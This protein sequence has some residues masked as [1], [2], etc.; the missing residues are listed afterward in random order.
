MPEWYVHIDPAPPVSQQFAVASRDLANLREACRRI[1]ETYGLTTHELVIL[2]NFTVYVWLNNPC[3]HIVIYPMLGLE[4][5]MLMLFI[6]SPVTVDE[7]Q[8]DT[9]DV[10]MSHLRTYIGI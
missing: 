10:L 6:E 4:K 9:V 5:Y 7:L 8:C 1:I 2:D 3:F